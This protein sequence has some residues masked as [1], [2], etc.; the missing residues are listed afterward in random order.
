MT[1]SAICKVGAE[2]KTAEEARGEKDEF[3]DGVEE[4]TKKRYYVK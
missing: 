4:E 1:F 3:E 2:L